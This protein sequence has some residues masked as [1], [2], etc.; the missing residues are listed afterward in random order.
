MNDRIVDNAL[1][2]DARIVKQGRIPSNFIFIDTLAIFLVPHEV[3]EVYKMHGVKVRI[4][5]SSK[6]SEKCDNRSW[7][8]TNFW[9]DVYNIINISLMLDFWIVDEKVEAQDDFILRLD[10]SL[11][12]IFGDSLLLDIDLRVPEWVLDK[13]EK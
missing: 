5:K 13:I 1:I 3:Q 9:Q 11:T 7:K 4:D 8:T 2:R 6:Y 10:E 12:A